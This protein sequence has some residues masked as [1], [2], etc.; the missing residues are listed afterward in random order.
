MARH[1]WRDDPRLVARRERYDRLREA[2]HGEHVTWQASVWRALKDWQAATALQHER[3]ELRTRGRQE[4]RE[5]AGAITDACQ[6]LKHA[7]D[8]D[9]TLLGDGRTRRRASTLLRELQ[10]ILEN[11]IAAYQGILTPSPR[12]AGPGRPR[13]TFWRACLQIQ[14]RH[15]DLTVETLARFLCR[16]V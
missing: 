13:D 12:R 4:M 2:E 6:T 14:Q 3:R 8:R 16:D 5:Q 10:T 1:S 7:I 9:D 15:P 11:A